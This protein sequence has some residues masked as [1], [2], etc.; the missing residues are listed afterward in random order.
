MPNEI[1]AAKSPSISPLRTS[2]PLGLSDAV[3]TFAIALYL[4]DFRTAENAGRLEDQHESKDGECR[5]VLVRD[6]EICRPERL[7]QADHQPAENSA[8]QRADAA[9]NG[10]GKRLDPR[11]EAIGE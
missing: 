11:H 4:L 1:R 5:N 7:D 10:R 9:E 3:L 8:R 2:P 6:G